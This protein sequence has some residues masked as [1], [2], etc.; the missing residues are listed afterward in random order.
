MV[1]PVA[2]SVAEY[3]VPT[4]P[5]DR[6]EVETESV[7]EAAATAM[8][9]DFVAVRRSESATSAVKGDVPEAVGVPEITPD[10]AFS[11]SP[12]GSDPLLVLQE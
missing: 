12:A 1:P 11:V 9:N 8:P 2:C 10:D 7:G 6:E 5:P 3:A 4:V